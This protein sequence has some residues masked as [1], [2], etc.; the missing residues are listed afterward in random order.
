MRAFKEV[1]S[2][3]A[4][5]GVFTG[6]YYRVAC[7]PTATIFLASRVKEV[8]NDTLYNSQTSF[9]S[10]VKWDRSRMWLSAEPTDV[11]FN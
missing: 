6:E 1:T 8:E 4:L 9:K 7:A 2:V 10:W 11:T 3:S 5:Q